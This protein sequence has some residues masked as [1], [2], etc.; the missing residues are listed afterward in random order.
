MSHRRYV[1]GMRHDSVTDDTYS[2]DM[3]AEEQGPGQR[4]ASTLKARRR[5]L[6]YTQDDLAEASGI[7]RQ[8]VIRLES[9]SASNPEAATLR[10][11]CRGAQVDIREVLVD[12]GYV[13]R[14]ELGLPPAPSPLEPI[15]LDAAAH[16]A[17]G[18]YSDFD[19]KQLSQLIKQALEF[20]R[21]RVSKTPPTEPSHNER[22]GG[23]PVRR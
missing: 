3:A 7:S 23:K 10:A 11:V 9:G 21:E 2:G 20:W 8:T 15:L 16:F 6:G 18:A 13:S 1:T 5:V 17:D 22:A 4:L 19:K 12:L 14:E